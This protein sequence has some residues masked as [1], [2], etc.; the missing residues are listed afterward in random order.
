MHL[1]MRSE[2]PSGPHFIHSSLRV[3][4]LRV[5]I[6]YGI[7]IGSSVFAGL[8]LVRDIQRDRQTNQ[9]RYGCNNR[10]HRIQC[11]AM[12]INNNLGVSRKRK[13][14]TSLD[15]NK[16]RDDGV[17]GWQWHQLDHNLCKQ[18][19]PRSRQITTPTPH[20]SISTGHMLT[21]GLQ[22]KLLSSV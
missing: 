8:P 4:P 21:D 15:L 12:R 7:M 10:P 13:G 18:S 6:P 3:E 20:H 9:P 2:N 14:K 19:A 5:H 11:T 22:I 1:L 17:L 16:A